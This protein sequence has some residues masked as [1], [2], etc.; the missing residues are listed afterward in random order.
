LPSV[1]STGIQG[2][3]SKLKFME[4]YTRET[5]VLNGDAQI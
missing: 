3:S 2:S 1:R 4:A 5:A